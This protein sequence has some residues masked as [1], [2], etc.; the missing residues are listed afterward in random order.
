MRSQGMMWM[1]L[2][3]ALVFCTG[4][5]VSGVRQ[6]RDWQHAGDLAVANDQPLEAAVFYRK[7]TQTF[8]GTSHARRAQKWNRTLNKR[9]ARPV[10]S[11]ASEDPGRWVEELFNFLTWP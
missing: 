8:P 6:A 7:I 3:G 11:P 2:S 10:R 4:A 9:L 1:A 5:S